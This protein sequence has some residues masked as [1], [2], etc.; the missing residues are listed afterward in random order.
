VR[1]APDPVFEYGSQRN[2]RADKVITEICLARGL[3]S[4]WF[5]AH[6]LIAACEG[7]VGEDEL[8]VFVEELKPH[9]RDALA[10]ALWKVS[11]GARP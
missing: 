3:D 5:L 11:R 6:K 7:K 4:L 8:R 2:A 9:Q 10:R 1:R